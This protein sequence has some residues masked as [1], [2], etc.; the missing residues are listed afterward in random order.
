MLELLENLCWQVGWEGLVSPWERKS[1]I[2]QA[3][4]PLLIPTR[5][6]AHSLICGATAITSTGSMKLPRWRN[7]WNLRAALGVARQ[8]SSIKLGTEGGGC[9]Q[10]SNRSKFCRITEF[11]P[12]KPKPPGTKTKRRN[13]HRSLVTP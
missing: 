4:R 11:L 1:S 8:M 7:L 12:S 2:A 13:M 9:S 3:F 10:K 5:L 6:H